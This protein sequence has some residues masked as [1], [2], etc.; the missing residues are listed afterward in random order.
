M[1]DKKRHL[2]RRQWTQQI[3]GLALSALPLSTTSWSA[4]SVPS[5]DLLKEVD[6]PRPDSRQLAWQNAE[7]GMF[8]HFDIPIFKPGWNW[9]SFRDLPSPADFNPQALD[10]DQWLEAAQSIGAKYAVLVAKHCSGFLTW[11]SDL[12]PYGVKQAKWR[13]GKGDLVADFVASCEK[14]NIKPGIY[15]SV[16]ANCF[17]EVDNPGRVNRGQGND[18]KRQAQY[19]E[20]QE[21]MLAELWGR[22]GDLFYI[23][24]D[25]GALSPS[26]GGPDLVPLYQR[27]Q[28]NANVFQG[29]S[30]TTRWVGN[31]RGVADY[32]CWATVKQR[33]ASGAG[34]PDGLVWQ[35]GECDVPIRGGEWFW[36]EKQT[37]LVHSLDTL[38][39]MYYRSVGHNCNLLLNANPNTAGLIPDTDMQRYAEFGREIKRRFDRPLAQTSGQ[40]RTLELTWPQPQRLDHVWIMEDIRYGER[41]RQYRIEARLTDGK[42]KSIA[43]G[44]AVGHKRIQR[45]DSI[46]T[47][48][49]RLT[50]DQSTATPIIR[51]FAAFQV[52]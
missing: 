41:I 44:T 49:L 13:D 29:P 10:T 31:E 3:G 32:P 24:F 5:Q 11:Q 14:Y 46:E 7:L 22:Y 2:N 17:W 18:P 9:R 42:W 23:W 16:T 21:Q 40:G 48:A 25:G 26:E 37:H 34:D 15:A 4:P 43:T 50:F 36:R 27:L 12:Y 33:N 6:N 30:A 39:D 20:A 47:T 52:G 28:P 45:F 35:P 8:Y 38:M 51:D 19:V 1:K